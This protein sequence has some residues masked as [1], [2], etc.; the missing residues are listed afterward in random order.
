MK[1]R[2]RVVT[3]EDVQSSLYYIHVDHPEDARLITPLPEPGS[4]DD[5]PASANRPPVPP[6]PRKAVPT[7]L[8]P[9]GVPAAPKRKPIPETLAPRN[10]VDNSHNINAASYNR[11][12]P[13]MLPYD[14]DRVDPL[15]SAPYLSEQYRPPLPPRRPTEPSSSIGTSLT[16][17]RRDPASSAQWN[18]A[19]VEDSPVPDISS[20]TANDSSVKKKTGAPLYIEVTNPGYSKFLHNS[21]QPH[22]VSRTSDLQ[23]KSQLSIN[24]SSL[25]PARAPFSLGPSSSLPGETNGTDNVFRR[26]LW[27][28]GSRYGNA[29]F[30]HRKINSHDSNMS[31]QSPRSSSE[32]LHRER[33]SMDLRPPG[34]PSPLLRD[35]QSYSTIQVSEKQ[36]SFRGYVFMSPWNGRCEFS[37]GAGGG[38]LKASVI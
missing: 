11:S 17:I 31:R 37:T 33:F 4:V 25:S 15:D 34:A 23:V 26:R 6:V 8:A 20:L 1:P 14:Y 35:D 22:H 38:S 2:D 13:R 28:E 18:V 9:P 27:M 7:S 19:H 32:V 24:P 21:E 12:S 36:S 3:A 10:D 5:R 30:G 16:I 29:G